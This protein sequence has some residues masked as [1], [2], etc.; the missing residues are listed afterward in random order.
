MFVYPSLVSLVSRPSPNQPQTSLLPSRLPRFLSAVPAASEAWP[1]SVRERCHLTFVENVLDRVSDR[2]ACL[3]A[4]PSARSLTHSF[5]DCMRVS[6]TISRR[7]RGPNSSSTA[8]TS[9]TSTTVATTT[10]LVAAAL[11]YRPKIVNIHVCS[12]VL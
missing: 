6:K 3:P 12:H 11:R 10:K 7:A 9:S 5:G 1:K 4:Q 2:L 8:T